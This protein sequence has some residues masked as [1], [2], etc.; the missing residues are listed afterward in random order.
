MPREGRGERCGVLLADDGRT[1]GERGRFLQRLYAGRWRAQGWPVSDR[2]LSG[3]QLAFDA[4]S[5]LVNP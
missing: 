3:L 5:F 2:L 1:A 4:R